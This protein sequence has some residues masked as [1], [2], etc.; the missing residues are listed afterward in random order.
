MLTQQL[1]ILA[2]SNEKELTEKRNRKSHFADV[3]SS[4]FCYFHTLPSFLAKSV[5][6]A[7]SYFRSRCFRSKFKIFR[8]YLLG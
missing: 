7:G 3:S 1:L 4:I 2:T 5:Q 6:K 8:F